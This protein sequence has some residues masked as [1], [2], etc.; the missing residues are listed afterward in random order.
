MVLLDKNTRNKVAKRKLK[1]SESV[2]PAVIENTSGKR[3]VVVGIDASTAVVGIC[4]LDY[5]TGDLILLTHKKLDK[6]KD[7]YD[8]GDNFTNDWVESDWIVKRVF[9]EEAAKKFSP[10][11]SSAGTIMV[12]GR[13]NGI[14][15]YMV[16]KWFNVKPIQIPV[17]SARKSIGVNI[18]Y[19]DKSKSTKEK[20]GCI[21]HAMFPDYPWVTRVAKVGKFKGQTI[22]DKTDE[23]R[24]DAVV[25]AKAGRIMFP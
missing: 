5:K 10:G 25:L 18:D 17:R 19:K 14:I 7:E 4:V 11:F 1:A 22:Y 16:Y 12:L 23:D 24:V 3:E 20:V 9:V 13:F 6:F 21:V 8:K 15:S 2:V